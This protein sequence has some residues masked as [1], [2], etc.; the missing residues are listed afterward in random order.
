MP[1]PALTPA[2][3]VRRLLRLLAGVVREAVRA[4][5][6]AQGL[7]HVPGPDPL[8]SLAEVAVV[9]G[10][11]KRTAERLVRRGEIGTVRAGSARRV[12]PAALDAYVRSAAR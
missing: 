2:R 1:R 4:E 11:S 5:L 9:L 7:S 10:V 6:A 8:L 3:L 12:H